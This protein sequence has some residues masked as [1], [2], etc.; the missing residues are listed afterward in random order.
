MATT[1]EVQY[2]VAKIYI[3]A[4]NRV[5][6]SGGL[7]NWVN[8]FQASVMTYNQIAEA[9]TSQDEYMAKYPS[10]LSNQDYVSQI[11]LNV[12]GRAADSNGLQNWTNQLNGLVF[13]KGTIMKAMLDVASEAGNTDGLR[14]TNQA[15]FGVDAVA[16]GKSVDIATQ[17]L[18]SITSDAS[19]ITTANTLMEDT[20]AP[21][22]TT[23]NIEEG[24][25]VPGANIDI[26]VTFSE[27]IVVNGI[28]ST[29]AIKIGTFTKQAL[30]ASKTSNTIAYKY[31]V[32][33]GISDTEQTV[34]VIADAITLNNTTMK[35][36]ALNVL[37]TTNSLTT[38]DKALVND[39]KAPSIVVN[40]AS[41]IANADQLIL[42]GTGFSS[43]LEQSES[44]SE[45]IA[46]RFDFTKLIWD[47][48]GD[49]DTVAETDAVPAI[50]NVSFTSADISF[51]KVL[52]DTQI[53]I[54]LSKT[55][56]SLET[57]TNYGHGASGTFVDTLDI[58]SGFV[59]DKVGNL[60]TDA[61]KNNI[62]IGIDG[63]FWG[64]SATD[65][66]TG[67]SDADTLYGQGGADTLYGI[68]GNDTLSGGDGNDTLV[69]GLGI[70]TLA[71]G[72]GSDTFVFKESTTDSIPTFT[73]V[74]GIDSISDLVLDGSNADRIDLEA[75][76][77]KVNTAV[78]GTVNKSTFIN[79]LNTLLSVSGGGF[80]TS[81]TDIASTLVTVSAG[82]LNAKTYLVVDIDADN[83]FTLK[84]FIVDVTGVTLTN[85]DT[86]IF[87]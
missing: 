19:S 65:R 63:V 51:A 5:P 55:F 81:L 67:T 6:D 74:E 64:T 43:I 79:D 2:E 9:F 42:N 62:L 40:S 71:G 18:Q 7:A 11:Y 26:V 41:Y 68:S 38:N 80:D 78:S 76:I 39:T 47:I 15:K 17:Q 30:Y 31:T 77:T 37:D 25:F 32:E 10:T 13:S 4:F 87:I 21:T 12:F 69:G 53:S 66:I 82:N 49:Y 28:D 46:S 85:F 24:N 54:V 61:I 48:D 29:L 84:D 70:D 36:A 57:A 86:S 83:S 44:S 20:T 23:I 60:S 34:S 75:T 27:D 14:L 45:D 1:Q 35:D 50:T 22:I 73:T 3:A 16:A 72:T 59:V 52:S 56:T 8:Q 33:D 58:L